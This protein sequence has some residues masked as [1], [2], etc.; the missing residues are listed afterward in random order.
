LARR[1]DRSIQ[2]GPSKK[3]GQQLLPGVNCFSQINLEP[4]AR[5]DYGAF[6]PAGAFVDVGGVSPPP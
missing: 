4:A 1:S 5:P 2:T 6:V 3:A